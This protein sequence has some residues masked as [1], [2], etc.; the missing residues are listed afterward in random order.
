MAGYL[1]SVDRLFNSILFASKTLGVFPFD[2]ISSTISLF[3]SYY[4]FLVFSGCLVQA[5]YIVFDPPELVKFSF[6]H[7]LLFR[8]QMIGLFVCMA[9][10]I[11]MIFLKRSRLGELFRNLGDL[12]VTQPE[13]EPK[14]RLIILYCF[15]QVA[16]IIYTSIFDFI[17]NQ[18]LDGTVLIA[19]CYYYAMITVIT[20]GTL[21]FVSI[22]E[23]VCCKLEAIT[24]KMR[25]L[26]SLSS[27]QFYLGDI[28]RYVVVYNK[29]TNVVTALNEVFNFQLLFISFVSFI[30]VTTNM[31]FIVDYI[32]STKIHN[33]EGSKDKAKIIPVFVGWIIIFSL[34]I[35]FPIH[36]CQRIVRQVSLIFEIL[37]P[38]SFQGKTNVHDVS[39]VNKIVIYVRAVIS[40][41]TCQ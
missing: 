13:K 9:I 5:A 21:P 6:I 11:F 37:F 8:C 31:Y 26:L 1:P 10:F 19:I 35:C 17:G 2:Q 7:N 25:A 12:K 27:A 15:I 22:L 38:S 36:S 39:D 30:N 28:L 14:F 29:S 18:P 4:S 41:E 20:S 32:V 34:L 23:V 24:A 16:V 40:H 33:V 3:W